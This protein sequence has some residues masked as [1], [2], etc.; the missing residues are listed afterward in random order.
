V[1]IDNL[2]RIEDNL[3]VVTSIVSLESEV[4]DGPTAL[5]FRELSQERVIVAISR[6]LQDDDVLEVVG[7]C[8]DDVLVSLSDLQLLVGFKAVWGNGDS[9]SGL[10]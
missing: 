1:C 2:P 3:V 5:I 4:I 7:D 6:G 9:T 8:V 10:K